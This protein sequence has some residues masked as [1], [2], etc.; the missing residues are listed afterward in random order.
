MKANVGTIDRALR[1]VVGGSLGKLQNISGS[2]TGNARYL[3]IVG[4]NIMIESSRSTKATALFSD[5]G[6]EIKKLAADISKIQSEDCH[7]CKKVNPIYK[8]GGE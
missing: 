5:F 8:E 2:I 1:I 6:D 4:M 7:I 3:N